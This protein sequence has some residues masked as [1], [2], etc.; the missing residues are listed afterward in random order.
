MNGSAPANILMVDDQPA[1][2]LT[3]R[4]ILEPLGHNLV[5]VNSGLDALEALM[6]QDFAV[7]LLDVKM[8]GMD[9][10]ETAELIHDHPRFETIPIIFVTGVHVTEFD[11]LKGYKAGAIDY[12]YIPVIP[13]IL[14]SKVAVLVEL[15]AKR[16]ELQSVNRE[17]A[18][19]N[20]QLADAN[21]TLQTEKTRELEQLNGH[22]QRANDD[23]SRSNLSL[24]NEIRERTRA[25]NLLKEA[26]VKRDEFL[27][28]L[29]HELRNPLSPLRNASHMLMLGE[30][31]D[32][33]IIWSRGVIERQLKH[34]IRLVDDLLDV[35]RIARGKIVLV[36]ERVNVAD[37]VAAAVETVQPLLD[38]KKQQ[39]EIAAV[40]PAPTVRG[41]PVRLSQVVGNLLHNAA[42]YTGEGGSIV[43]ATRV[44]DGSAEVCVRDSGIGI[45]KESMPR[46]FELFTQIPSERANTGGGLGIGLALVRALVELHGGD[47][48]VAS[49]GIDQGSEF[50]V[51]LPLFAAETAAVDAAQTTLHSEPLAPVRRNIL[52]ADDNQDALESLA[53]MLRLEGHEVHCAS[54]GEEALALA[55]LRKP[56]IVVLDVGMPKLDGCE[57]ARRIRAESWGRDAVLVALTGWGQDID[58]R[59]SR[60]AGFDMHLVKPVDPATICD[61]LVTQ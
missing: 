54:D 36:S 17:L 14:R 61:M 10:F 20:Q 3:Y 15:Y 53:L 34:M 44:R 27:A 6:K 25:E 39:L 41:D 1:R 13:E 19:S 55:G 16:R 58:R 42:K 33:K 32:P 30:T 8:P 45:S 46:I 59:R 9:G 52:I 29:S 26:V 56:E 24:E 21:T 47:I 51:R 50:T 22:L 5:A 49:D 23:L 28:M 31:Q 43:L 48:R 11:R 38:Q 7:V 18:E 2:L 37:I 40:E 60:E 4:A 35:S 12:V 57:V